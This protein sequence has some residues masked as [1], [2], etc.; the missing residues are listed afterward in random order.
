MVVGCCAEHACG[1][2]GCAAGSVCGLGGSATG[3]KRG[4]GHPTS[5]PTGI[6]CTGIVRTGIARTGIGR[7][8]G[9]GARIERVGSPHRSG[10]AVTGSGCSHAITRSIGWDGLGRQ[11]CSWCGCYWCERYWCGWCRCCCS[12]GR[13]C[14][15]WNDWGPRCRATSWSIAVVGC[16]DVSGD[17]GRTES[18][19]DPSCTCR[20]CHVAASHL[21]VTPY[22]PN[23]AG[24]TTSST[25]AAADCAYRVASHSYRSVSCS[26][27]VAS[28]S[29]RAASKTATEPWKR[30]CVDV[31]RVSTT[32]GCWAAIGVG[33]HPQHRPPH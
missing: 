13:V 30:R 20:D 16:G 1:I 9:V 11:W 22:Y 21:R 2:G 17:L 3:G 18:I 25:C 5:W 26:C 19:V 15:R 28:C 31:S 7:R 32:G 4:V 14:G 24:P 8:D 23:V 12:C 29:Y 27:R 6:V 10:G 33:A